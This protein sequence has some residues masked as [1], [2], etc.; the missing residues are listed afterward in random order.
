MMA[1][2]I[3]DEHTQRNSR[4]LEAFIKYF[5]GVIVFPMCNHFSEARVMLKRGIHM[6][7]V[8]YVSPR[9]HH[10]DL[11]VL[12]ECSRWDNAQ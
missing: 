11:R 12:T 5:S 4:L 6:R 7:D 2:G 10:C 8:R 9:Q 3:Q 1:S